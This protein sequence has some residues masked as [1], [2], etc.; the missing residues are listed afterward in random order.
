MKKLFAAVM[1]F[2]ASLS[3]VSFADYGH[4]HGNDYGHGHGHGHGHNRVSCV[5]RNLRGMTF[6]ASSR[7]R[8]RAEERAL[9]RCYQAGSR[10]CRIVACY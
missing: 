2:G 1:V 7:N 8:Y 5:A 10:H 3:S 6:T 9:D 4:G